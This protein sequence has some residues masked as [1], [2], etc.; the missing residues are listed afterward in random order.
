MITHA[1][2]LFETMASDIQQK[3]IYQLAAV[4]YWVG[5]S[6]A[7]CREFAS[8]TLVYLNCI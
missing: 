1:L 5:V 6:A 2:D 4:S 7:R 3:V 8:S